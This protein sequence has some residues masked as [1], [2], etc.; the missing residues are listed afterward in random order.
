L[1]TSSPLDLQLA[2]PPDVNARF[3]QIKNYPVHY[4]YMKQF[5][6]GRASPPTEAPILI[7]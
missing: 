6:A 3:W 5:H 1:E 7:V 2:A 4:K